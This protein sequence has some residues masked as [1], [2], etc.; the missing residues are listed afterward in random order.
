MPKDILKD[1]ALVVA[2]RFSN[3]LWLTFAF[4][5]IGCNWEAVAYF[6][7]ST[8]EIEVRLMILQTIYL[9]W[10]KGFWMPLLI[11]TGYLLLMP[12][13]IFGYKKAIHTA[14]IKLALLASDEEER[15]LKDAIKVAKQKKE[16]SLIESGAKD[17]QELNKLRDQ[18]QHE[19]NTVRLDNQS[20][21]TQLTTLQKDISQKDSK[22]KKY[23]SDIK[24]WELASETL[25]AQLS[26]SE[27]NK[28]D[29][30]KYSIELEQVAHKYQ[31]YQSQLLTIHK[32]L[33]DHSGV[34]MRTFNSKNNVIPSS[35]RTRLDEIAGNIND[36]LIQINMTPE[37][38]RPASFG[39]K[40]A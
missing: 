31:E 27:D 32:D 23:S 11:A 18:L 17:I 19:L 9:N 6:F 36:I 30:K 39:D 13:F 8:K 4:A 34:I 14:K 38:E 25:K 29:I 16:H 37:P 35:I 33:V 22:I 3:P 40:V 26:D 12:W 28:E 15:F 1:A 20:I 21:N 7:M 24:R 10:T 2:H 5:W